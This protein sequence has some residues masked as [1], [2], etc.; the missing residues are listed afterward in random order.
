M[1]VML[2]PEEIL[3]NLLVNHV[4]STHLLRIDLTFSRDWAVF[5]GDL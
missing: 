4:T 2:D 3:R 5:D 1:S